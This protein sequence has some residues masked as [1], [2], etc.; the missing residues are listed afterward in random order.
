M[1]KYKCL[2]YYIVYE[3]EEYGNMLVVYFEFRFFFRVFKEY[4]N[5]I[6]LVK[7]VFWL[8]NLFLYLFRWFLIDFRFF[9]VVG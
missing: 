5:Y 7:Y 2:V 4:D 9:V 3:S 6:Y 1:L 8:K